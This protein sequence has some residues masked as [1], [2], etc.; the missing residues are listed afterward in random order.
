MNKSIAYLIVFFG[1]LI[2]MI[3]S[4]AILPADLAGAVVFVTLFLGYFSL[5][6]IGST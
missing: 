6:A 1:S 3:I 2:G 5:L 4:C